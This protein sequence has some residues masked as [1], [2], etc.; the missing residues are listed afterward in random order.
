MERSAIIRAINHIELD[1]KETA[2]PSYTIPEHLEVKCKQVI[3]D[4]KI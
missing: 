2:K 3:T 4:F 1:G